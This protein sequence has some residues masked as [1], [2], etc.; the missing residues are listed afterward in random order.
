MINSYFIFLIILCGDKH[1]DKS[2]MDISIYFS[3][4]I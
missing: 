4:N 1:L 3:D 2:N